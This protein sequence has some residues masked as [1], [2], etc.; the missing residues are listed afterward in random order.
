MQDKD[1]ESGAVR[2]AL[3]S[4]VLCTFYY[5]KIRSVSS[6]SFLFSSFLPLLGLHPR[7][8]EVP[9]LWVESELQ[10]PAYATATAT[11]DPSRVYNLYHSSWQHQMVYP[12]SEARDQTQNLM[13][14]SWIHF[15]CVTMGTSRSV[16]SYYLTLLISRKDLKHLW[17]RVSRGG[18]VERP[19]G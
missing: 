5:S 8:M 1:K 15:H 3:N 2:A 13:V 6:S 17:D 7:H 12:L 11:T 16:S 14:L 10:L 9:R 18:E 4:Q 19:H